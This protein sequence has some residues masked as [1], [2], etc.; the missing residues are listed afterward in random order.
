[1][2]FQLSPGVNVSE[3]DLTTVVPGVATTDAAIAGVF[4]WGPVGDR[5]LIDSETKL[6]SVFGPPSAN[7]YETWFTAAN[8]LAYSSTLHVV[9]AANTTFATAS[10]GA[11]NAY[12][13]TGTVATGIAIKNQ[14]D[15]DAQDGS[16]DADIRFAA[17]WPGAIGNSLKVS[18]CDS[19]DAFTSALQANG[20]NA[21][22]NYD[23]SAE[24]TVSIGSTSLTLSVIPGGTG[25]A[26]DANTY[27][28][29][30]AA[31]LAVGDIISL[32][33]TSIGY[34][35]NK[36]TA[37]GSVSSNSTGGYATITLEDPYRLAT[38]FAANSSLNDEVT[39]YWEYYSLVDSAPMTSAFVEAAGSSAVDT[40]HVVVVDQDGKFSG[41]PGAILETFAHVSRATDAKGVGGATNYYKTVINDGSDY[42][43]AVGDRS[44]AASA[45]AASV[46]TSTNKSAMSLSFVGGTDGYTE[47]T[48][49][50]AVIAAAYDV[51][52][53]AEDTDI[54]LILQGKPI[55]G[56]SG[57]N[58][59]VS[60]QLAN[61][62]ID[63][64][65]E[66]RKDCVVF[67]SPDDS[68]VTSNRGNEAVALVNWRG[69]V[70]SSSYAVMD[71][72]Y[73]YQY[74]KYNDV[75]RWVPLNG[76][77]AGLCARTDNL[78][79]PWW[80]PAGPTRGQIKNLVKLRWNP[81]SRA[82]RDMLYK[83][84]IN[85][86][87]TFTGQ[88]TYLYGDKTLLNQSSAFDRINV[89][90]LFIVLEKAIS[91]ASKMFLF[92]F[93]DEFT[94][95]QFK[96][97]VTPYLRDVQGRRG[98]TDFLVVCDGTN[99]TAERIDRNEFWGDIYIK[100]ARSINYIN[101]NFIA[102]RTGVQF[103][104]IVGNFG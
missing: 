99:N 76:D 52:A 91:T 16:F 72:G 77:I 60:W 51:F 22:E 88:G 41:T 63:N 39:R 15:F 86:V 78:R 53:S 30:L 43:W 32:G 59:A 57:T 50:L 1:M 61:Y 54:S 83:N 68:V 89:R 9:R 93:N 101:L 46:V 56:T 97:M 19:T 27:V 49:P 44:G 4:Q 81:G 34:Q 7:N 18:V 10:V 71:S 14:A 37:I 31:N 3:Y 87:V 25:T 92:E 66:I 58:S 2:A 29:A 5:V 6:K 84:S 20:Q 79:D 38:D 11:L 24:F 75:Y 82:M 23:V 103:S 42:V 95:S 45:V 55:G 100:P 62:L 102:V 67:V 40:M 69:S 65:A 64:I 8:F 80:S 21:S 94:R 33:N 28:R 98:I 47:S 48:I 12:A 96:N 35:L 90:R 104:E 85:P 74:D 70:H 13:N 17:K 26:A 73:K 36:I